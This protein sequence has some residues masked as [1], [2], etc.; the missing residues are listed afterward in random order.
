M[1]SEEKEM[2]QVTNN[3][4][5][6]TRGETAVYDATIM[7]KKGAPLIIAP[8][9]NEEYFIEFIVR[10]TAQDRTKT[11]FRVEL[12]LVDLHKFDRVTLIRHLDDWE[13]AVDPESEFKNYLHYH[14]DEET[15]TYSYR[16]WDGLKW[17]EYSFRIMFGFP[18]KTIDELK[19]GKYVY[20]INLFSR[21][22]AIAFKKKFI[23]YTR[24]CRRR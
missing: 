9:E 23:R 18:Y 7:T 14:Y 3:N 15:E 4:I 2:Y 10:P 13:D 6:I 19:P 22:G 16:R 24:F 11:I 17:V 12:D 20:E 1:Q 21:G 8:L 5:Y